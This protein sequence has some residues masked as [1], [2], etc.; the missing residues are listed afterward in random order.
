M[1]RPSVLQ[2]PEVSWLDPEDRASIPDAWVITVTVQRLTNIVW[3][4]IPQPAHEII[5][6]DFQRV[7]I[8][9]DCAER[10]VA[11]E[12]NE[13]LLLLDNQER[14]AQW[15]LLIMWLL[16]KGFGIAL[17]WPMVARMAGGNTEFTPPPQMAQVTP[18]SSWYQA[19][20]WMP[21]ESDLY[22]ALTLQLA[23]ALAIGWGF[24]KEQAAVMHVH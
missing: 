24:G 9:G 3:E 18:T 2:P 21:E 11:L 23:D 10:R 17:V 6:L 20:H 7:L 15:E 4:R 14:S 12:S 19:F 1:R 22:R 16:A 13:V 8:L 5:A